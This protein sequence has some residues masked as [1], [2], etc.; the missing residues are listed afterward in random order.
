M[1]IVTND[2]GCGTSSAILDYETD[3]VVICSESDY[4]HIYE[5]NDDILFIGHDF[6]LYL[7]DTPE[8]VERWI[9]HKG[10]KIV[11]CFE[12]IDAIIPAWAHKSHYSINMCSQ[13]ADELWATDERDCDKYNISWLP[14]W[15]S[16]RFFERR[17]RPIETEKILFSGQA[18]NPEYHHRNTLLTQIFED[19][20]MSNRFEVTNT[21]RSMSWNDYI[22][23]FLKY[24]VILNPMGVLKGC[25]TRTYETLISGRVLLQQEDQIG[26]QRHRELLQRHPNVLFFKTYDD[27][28]E[29]VLGVDLLTLV[30]T[31]TTEQYEENNLFSRISMMRGES[32]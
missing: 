14:Q 6:L 15:S 5:E 9:S 30:Q 16:P 20:D 7:W 10:K 27:L 13:F 29:I 21:D 32:E 8:K 22:D 12:A 31:E 11:W 23:N 25:N 26:Y 18:G 19:P 1:K 24:P 4:E 28:K 2:Y 3:S 17:A